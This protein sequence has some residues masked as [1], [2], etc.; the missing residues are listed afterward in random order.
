MAIFI[1]AN[2]YAKELS[3]FQRKIQRRSKILAF[4]KGAASFEDQILS[5]IATDDIEGTDAV[6]TFLGEYSP[7]T[8]RLDFLINQYLFHPKA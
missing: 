5:D 6:K 1:C 7:G 4:A 8:D 2:I 3:R